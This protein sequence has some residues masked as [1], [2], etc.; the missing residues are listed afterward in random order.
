[1]LYNSIVE[2]DVNLM[3]TYYLCV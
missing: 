3:S 2:N 1:M